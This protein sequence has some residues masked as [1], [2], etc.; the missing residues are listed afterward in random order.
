MTESETR[1]V[2]QGIELRPFTP[3]DVPAAKR[4]D[5]IAF[6]EPFDPA[7]EKP[8]IEG[9][10]LERSL[11]A[12]ADGG[13][14]GTSALLTLELTLPGGTRIPAAGLTW[15]SVLPTHRRRGILR[16]L[17][18]RQLAAARDRGDLV[19]CLLA[20]E[21]HLYGR[22][23]YGPATFHVEARLDTGKAHFRTPVNVPGRMRMLFDPEPV[24]AL[25][26]VWEQVRRQQVGAVS[27][28][29]VWWAGSIRDEAAKP[30]RLLITLHE[31][32]EGEPDGYAVY[33]F[34]PEW[35]EGLGKGRV[36]VVD[37]ASPDPAVRLVL[38]RHLL[39]TDLACEVQAERIPVDDGLRWQLLEPR[40]LRTVTLADDLWLRPLDVRACLEARTYAGADRLLLQVSDDLF[41][42]NQGVFELTVAEGTGSCRR[43]QAAPDLTLDVAQL[44]SVLL[45]GVAFARLA[46]AGYVAERSQGALSRA[47]HLFN[48]QPAPFSGTQF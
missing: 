6:G 48:V 26:P 44:G 3:A 33:R 10:P 15:V 35:R 37:L 25:A 30:G 34:I 18:E 11:G 4:A 27:R 38:W 43:V 13:L 39:D 28:D 21:S 12:F 5:A 1:P 14:V 16:A 47:D 24:A 23:G 17:M 19:S 31:T 45:G 8:M 29:P 7:F 2:P 40:Q 36:V 46:E 32:E 20:S 41:P 9:L 42:D 22:F